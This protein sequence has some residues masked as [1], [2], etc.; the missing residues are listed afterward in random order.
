MI[1]GMWAA[2]TGM[3][4]QQLRLDVISNNLA[5]VNTTGF[6]KS[7]AEFEDLIYQTLKQP[8]GELAGGG[9]V[10][11]GIQVG[12]GVR[13]VSVEKMFSQG[14]YVHT[15][16]E[17]DMAI[18][19]RGFFKILNNG[20]EYYSRAGSFKMDKDG[21]ITTANG[22]RLQPEFSIPNQTVTITIDSGGKITCFDSDNTPISSGS[23]PLYTFPNE[24]GLSSVGRNLFQVTE[25]SGDAIEGEPG[26][27]GVGTIAQGYLEMSNVNVVEEMVNM[28]ITQRAYELNSKAIQTADDMLQR[29]NNLKA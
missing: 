2:A 7:R 13:P 22:D 18:E 1:R 25:A 9:Q 3:G 27:E 6:K 11:S 5:N 23:I 21:Y 17:L 15:E 26:L 28:I 4:A 19:G 14:D 20:V 8:G 16:N 29:A 24:A 10:P 12:M